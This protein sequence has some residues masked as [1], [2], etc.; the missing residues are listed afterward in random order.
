MLEAARNVQGEQLCMNSSFGVCG[1]ALLNL[2]V[3]KNRY[4]AGSFI[5]GEQLSAARETES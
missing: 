4:V 5:M 1:E 3:V 2:L